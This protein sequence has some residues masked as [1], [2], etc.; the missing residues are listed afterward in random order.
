MPGQPLPDNG[1]FGA[2]G[3]SFRFEQSGYYLAGITHH[4]ISFIDKGRVD[5]IRPG[6]IYSIYTQ[7]TLGR[8]KI[9]LKPVEIGTVVV[10]RTE[11]TT[12]T[13]YVTKALDKIEPGEKIRTP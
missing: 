7:Q 3:G 8:R 4:V 5:N 12:S 2:E 13:V 11:E 10:L 9:P 6:Q 1:V